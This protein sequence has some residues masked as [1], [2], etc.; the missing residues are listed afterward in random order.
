MPRLLTALG[1][2]GLLL[3]EALYWWLDEPTGPLWLRV[4]VAGLCF[5]YALLM[6]LVPRLRRFAYPSAAAIAVIIT[7]ENV[8]RMHLVEFTFSHSMPMLVVIAGASY[9]FREYSHMAM[10]LLAS[11]ISLTIT[12]ALTPEPQVSPLIYVS[13][14][15]V[16]CLLTFLVFGT[17]VRQHNE[18]Q[19]QEQVLAAVV[20]GSYGGLLMFRGDNPELVVAND[21][22]RQLLAGNHPGEL[23]NALTRNVGRHLGI[24]PED[25]M[26]HTRKARFWH[27]EVPFLIGAQRF[28]T[29]VWL[30]HLELAGER[31][32]LVGLFDV[33]A[34]RQAMAALTRSEL[35]LERSQRVGGL[36]SWD[37]NLETLQLSWSPELFRIYGMEGQ[38][39]PTVEET[40]AM[41]E[42]ES[43]AEC[44]VAMQAAIT[45][46]HRVDMLVR[47]KLG[48][49]GRRWLKLVGE[50]MDIEGEP[51]LLGITQ[52]VTADKLAEQELVQAKEVAEQALKVR[53]EFLANM[54]HEIR[55]P[56]NGVIGT[57]SL[58]MDSQLDSAQRELLETIR[59]SGESLLR[60]INDILDFSKIDA[61][62]VDLEHVP[63]ET[64]M[65]FTGVLEPLAMEA[66]AKGVELQLDVAED[67]PAALVGDVTRLRQILVNLVH[68]AIKFTARGR[69]AVSVRG[70]AAAPGGFSLVLAV[71]DTGVGIP[72]ASI[73][74]LFDAFVQ[75]DASTTRR[76]GGTGLG[77]SIC[78][79]LA[80][81]MGGRIHV[82][83]EPGVGSTFRLE[84]LLPV[85]EALPGAR[86]AVPGTAP[87]RAGPLQ[88]LLAE[89]NAVNQRVATRMLER[90]GCAVDTVENGRQAVDAVRSHR[91]DLVLMDVQ[92][93]EVDGLEATRQIRDLPDIP[94]PRVIALTANAMADDRQRCL[95]AGMNDFLTK[96]IT[97]ETLATKLTAP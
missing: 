54:S 19:A 47:A 45:R 68:N 77:L 87:G 1:G 75:Q 31:V 25:V 34:R 89:D 12:I 66:R 69:V 56:M 58:L 13:S 23:L 76:F 2:A 38:P 4:C 33:T 24:P 92:M 71:T 96:P 7:A 40:V 20:E 5:A 49:T 46:E 52:D 55:T 94:Q 84:L 26:Q 14:L 70:A 35:M 64:K 81:L 15:W 41:L 79:R 32:M 86:E 80:Q 8:V 62:R 3:F 11:A 88:V 17:R 36:G 43:Q 48:Q 9:A 73:E 21:R 39:Q 63:F 74:Q 60:L 91:Y 10:Y 50:V 6:Q 72:A 37:I 18:V 57:A 53:S 67:V 95:T 51:H 16:F 97:L 28:W 29:D 61:G 22:A 65:L 30:R 83:S 82:E 90:L 27:D 59:V 93:P 78:Q 42:P 85:A 44:R